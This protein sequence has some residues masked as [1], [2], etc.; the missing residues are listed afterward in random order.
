MPI[1]EWT[2]FG[3]VAAL[4]V[5]VLDLHPSG[6]VLGNLILGICGAVS[7][8]LLSSFLFATNKSPLAQL[9]F[10][11]ILGFTFGLL[12]LSRLLRRL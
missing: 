12:T 5:N 7:G 3:V 1:L 11:I 4:I 6:G 2:I 8:G 9:T 10:L